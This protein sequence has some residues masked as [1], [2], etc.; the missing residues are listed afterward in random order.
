MDNF[1]HDFSSIFDGF[2]LPKRSQNG[3]FLNDFSKTPILWKL[4]PLSSEN[5]FFE[6]RSLQKCNPKRCRNALE[7]NIAKKHAKTR[8]GAPF[9]PPKTSPKPNWTRIYRVS[10][11]VCFATLWKPH[12]NRRKLTGVG[13]CKASKWLRIWLGLLHPSIDLPLVALITNAWFLEAGFLKWCW[14][15][16]S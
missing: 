15:L 4:A 8:F 16:R 5:L 3:A 9:W 11:D 13:V 10:N 1:E 2:D 12:G 7:K 6:V 14:K